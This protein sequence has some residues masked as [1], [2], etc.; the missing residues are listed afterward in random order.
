MA[1]VD[2]ILDNNN[3]LEEETIK[4]A[5]SEAHLYEKNPITFKTKQIN[6]T[7]DLARLST[8]VTPMYIKNPMYAKNRLSAAIES[9]SATT[10]LNNT[11]KDDRSFLIEPSPSGVTRI[12]INSFDLNNNQ[13]SQV[14]NVNSIYNPMN[15]S[16]KPVTVQF[17]TN[18]HYPMQF[19]TFQ[20]DLSQ[21]PSGIITNAQHY[22]YNHYNN[23]TDSCTS[24]IKTLNANYEESQQVQK[25]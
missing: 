14:S 17:N 7:A 24:P 6:T 23:K 8:E 3:R 1:Q 12:K 20:P 25:G 11:T 4:E 5:S 21:R 16:Y 2:S 13:V 10:N 18:P 19:S 15:T 22:Q 9:V